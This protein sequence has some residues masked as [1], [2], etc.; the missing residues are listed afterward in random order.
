M[1]F[2]EYICVL[3]YEATC[4]GE[5]YY[6]N[7]IIEFPSVLLKWDGKNY[8]FIS[9]F[10]KFCKPLL[11]PFVSK[12]C[13]ELTGITQE[14]VDNGG[15]FPEVLEDHYNWL[16]AYTNGNFYILTCGY[17]D[18][19]VVMINECKKWGICPKYQYRRLV[20]IKNE[21]RNFYKKERGVG[22]ATMLKEL[23][24][25]LEGRHHSGLDDCKNICKILQRM[26]VDGYKFHN[27]SVVK[28]TEKSYIVNARKKKSIDNAKLAEKRFFKKPEIEYL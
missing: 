24:I 18:L 6:N 4:D 1:D 3:D 2:P 22:M 10:Q 11:K 16:M 13:Y 26:I 27:D 17:W 8:Q 15:N 14:Q 9:E 20:N 7:E 5:K 28:I 25:E 19:G 12:F 21:Y 23:G